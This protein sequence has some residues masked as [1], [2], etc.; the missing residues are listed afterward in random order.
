MDVAMSV[1][2]VRFSQSR[3]EGRPQEKTLS[4]LNRHVLQASSLCQNAHTYAM[5]DIIQ[6]VG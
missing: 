4:I 6:I 5:T 3:Y 2:K 1:P